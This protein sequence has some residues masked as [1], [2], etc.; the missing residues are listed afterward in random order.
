[1]DCRRRPPRCSS[2]T[3]RGSPAALSC[4]SY[5]TLEAV[6]KPS[7][8]VSPR[9]WP[10]PP[11]TRTFAGVL[12]GLAGLVALSVV[13]GLLLVAPLAPAITISGHAASTAASLFDGM[14]SYLEIDR[15]ML[16]TTIY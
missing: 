14:P 7:S 16:P 15:L 11:Y 4:F 1:M 6:V 9:A 13:A 12:G 10:S 5:R 3:H 2:R 8:E